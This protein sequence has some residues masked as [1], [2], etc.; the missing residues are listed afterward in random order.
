MLG[1]EKRKYLTDENE[2]VDEFQ[3]LQLS[4][5][6]SMLQR[7]AKFRSSLFI[8]FSRYFLVYLIYPA[9]F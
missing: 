8:F 1:I 2:N 5:Y 9:S 6:T 7:L 3:G 4:I